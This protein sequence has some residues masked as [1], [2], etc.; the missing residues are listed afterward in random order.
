MYKQKH[1]WIEKLTLIK[2]IWLLSQGRNIQ[3]FYTSYS[4]IAFYLAKFLKNTKFIQPEKGILNSNGK[5][6][7]Y[8]VENKIYNYVL[9][10]FNLLS[11]EKSIPSE[12]QLFKDEWQRILKSHVDFLIKKKMITILFIKNQYDNNNLKKTDKIFFIGDRFMFDKTFYNLLSKDYPKF[13]IIIWPDFYFIFNRIFKIFK[14]FALVLYSY[15]YQIFR[16][17]YQNKK[18]KAHIFEEH[19]MN[20]FDRYP[21]AGHLFWFESSRIDPQ[22]IVLYFDR[23]D[24]RINRKIIKDIS[25]FNMNSLNMIHP[26]INVAHPFALLINTFKAIKLFKSINYEKIDIWFTQINYYFLINCYKEAFKKYNCKIIHQHQEFWPKTLCMALAI[27]MEKGIFVWNHWSVDHF[28][29]S[30]FNWGFADIIFSWGEY[31]DG[32]FNSHNFSYKYLFQTGLIASDGNF[33]FSK[34]NKNILT[35]KL[36][37]DLDLVINILDSTFGTTHQNSLNSMIYF[38]KKILSNILERENWGAIIKSKGNSFKKIVNNK[39]IANLVKLLEKDNRI[40]ILPS[41]IK[42][43]T[44]AKISD[45]SV[46]YGINSAGV[47]AALSGSN[48]IYWNLPGVFEHPLM[49]LKNKD[50][51]IFNTIDE[52]VKALDQFIS[53]DKNIGNHDNCLNLFDPFRDDQGRKRVGE[54]MSKLFSDL[55]KNIDLNE[56]LIKIKREYELKWG[57]QYVYIYGK[58][59]NHIGNKLWERVKKNINNTN[60]EK[61]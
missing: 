1:I 61:K 50:N 40:C 31:N 60:L 30:Y 16:Y 54:I 3:I 23:K 6:M 12:M 37:S 58:G 10:I 8:E 48:S 39:E 27:R 4:S 2:C 5:A 25:R 18:N 33:N 56:S 20:I 44:S 11:L 35:K 22:D 57:K 52:I 41:E 46:C 9:K 55:K 47:I 28:P 29:I 7:I 17:D 32:Y 34:E 19:I 45:I 15:C 53:G 21:D 38:Y 36:S 13:S 51:L 42:V 26:V 24:L 14:L 43:S 49:Y 59:Y